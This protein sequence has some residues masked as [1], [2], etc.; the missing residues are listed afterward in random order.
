MRSM[1]VVQYLKWD[2][3]DSA[4]DRAGQSLGLA[5]EKSGFINGRRSIYRFFRD[6]LAMPGQ[7]SHVLQRFIGLVKNTFVSAKADSLTMSTALIYDKVRDYPDPLGRSVTG[8]PS[9]ASIPFWWP[10]LYTS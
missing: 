7:W 5:Y 1:A 3:I 8:H 10:A 4:F 2:L 6:L 9:A